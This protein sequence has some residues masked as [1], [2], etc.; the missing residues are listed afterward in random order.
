MGDR[1]GKIGKHYSFK[2]MM[3]RMQWGLGSEQ[4]KPCKNKRMWIGTQGERNITSAYGAGNTHGQKQ[5]LRWKKEWEPQKTQLIPTRIVIYPHMGPGVCRAQRNWKSSL[6]F[7]YL[8]TVQWQE[9]ILRGLTRICLRV[10]IPCM[11][12]SLGIQSKGYRCS[13]NLE[14]VDS[15]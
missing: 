13:S 2:W 4:M 9:A 3:A 11:V 14:E 10:K 5:R 15:L 7:L 6:F 12:L 8:V 1:P